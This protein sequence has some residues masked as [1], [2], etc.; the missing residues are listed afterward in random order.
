MFSKHAKFVLKTENF[1]KQRKQIPCFKIF[2]ISPHSCRKAD[3]DCRS[4]YLN[5]IKGMVFNAHN[6]G[7]IMWTKRVS[8]SKF[9]LQMNP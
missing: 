7:L 9:Y 4:S 8:R 3:F 5:I 2:A 6:H 1:L